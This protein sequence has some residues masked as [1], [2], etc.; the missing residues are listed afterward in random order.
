MGRAPLTLVCLHHS[1]GGS[2]NDGED[3]P[4][5]GSLTPATDL[6]GDRS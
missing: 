2:K 6:L 4:R 1:R 3:A 5:G